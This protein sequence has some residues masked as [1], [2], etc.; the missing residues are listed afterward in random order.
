VGGGA[1][2]DDREALTGT[3]LFAYELEG[4]GRRPSELHHSYIGRDAEKRREPMAGGQ[5]ITLESALTSLEQDVEA[6]ARAATAAVR[7]IRALQKAVKQGE[8]RKLNSNIA[9]AA[10]AMRALSQ[11]FANA[12]KGWAFDAEGYLSGGAFAQELIESARKQ[13][14][15]IVEQDERLYCYPSLIRILPGEQSVR[16]DKAREGRLR[17]SVLVAHLKEIQQHPPRFRPEAFL[18][19]LYEAY[20]RLNSQQ[21]RSLPGTSRVIRLLQIYE[22]LTI[23]PGMSREY[24]KAEFARDVY[25]LDRSGVTKTRSGA[26]VEFPA[27][28]GTKTPSATISVITENGRQKTYYGI[29]FESPV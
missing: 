29:S 4:I 25:L 23:L 8:L 12:E 10:Q 1:E 5:D 24:T 3:P 22:M 21:K 26:I 18:E 20:R 14:V 9:A 19:G 16:I 7:A 2:K 13:G 17:P 28:T 6:T 15:R 27:S 11:Q